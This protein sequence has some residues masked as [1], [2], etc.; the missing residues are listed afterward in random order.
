V[1]G[2]GFLHAYQ[3]HPAIGISH[4]RNRLLQLAWKLFFEVQQRS[5]FSLR[6]KELFDVLK[7]NFV[8]W[9]VEQAIAPMLDFDQSN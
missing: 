7:R 1:A 2:R 8:Y 9:D 3:D 5:F 6:L 4:G